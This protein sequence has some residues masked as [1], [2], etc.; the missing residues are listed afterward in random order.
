MLPI[1]KRMSAREASA[2]TPRERV[3]TAPGSTRQKKKANQAAQPDVS[4]H[5]TLV[6]VMLPSS[7]DKQ[8]LEYSK[9]NKSKTLEKHQINSN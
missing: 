2:T 1:V 8:I 5:H 6:L 4:A 9:D 3:K 7:I